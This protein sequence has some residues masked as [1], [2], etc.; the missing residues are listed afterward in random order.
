MLKVYVVEAFNAPSV[1]WWLVT[2]PESE[3][4][5]PV[6]VV[7]QYS[8]FEFDGTSVIHLIIAEF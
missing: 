3:P 7:I 8:T 6:T 2:K 4:E 1:I 5:S